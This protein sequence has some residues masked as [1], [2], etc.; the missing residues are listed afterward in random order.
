[1][2]ANYEVIQEETRFKGHFGNIPYPTIERWELFPDRPGIFLRRP[3]ELSSGDEAV[4]ALEAVVGRWGLMA[5][6]SSEKGLKLATYNAK[7]ETASKL[8]TYSHAWKSR[9]RVIV[10]ADAFYEPD[11]RSGKAVRTR[12]ELAGGEPM[13]IAGL[14]DRWRTSGGEL[15]ETYTM[16]TINADD[17]PLLKH[18]HAPGKEKRMIVI[19]PPDLYDAWLD[20]PVEETMDFMR[21]YPAEGLVATPAPRSKT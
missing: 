4:P 2:C 15:L 14:W 5:P 17:H 9:Q 21:Q 6:R 13:G 3:P 18:Y 16:L 12:F 7:S 1:M 20:C 19:L 8:F 11:W 10:P